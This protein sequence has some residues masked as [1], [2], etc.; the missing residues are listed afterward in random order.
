MNPIIRNEVEI[1]YPDSDGKPMADN[2]KQFECITKIKGNLDILFADNKDVFVAGD[3]LWY[4]VEGEPKIRIAPDVMV[5]IGRP[6]GHRGSYQQWKEGNIPPKVVFEILSPGNRYSEMLQK[7]E[8]YQ[9]Y[10][11]EEYYVYDPDKHDFSV[12]LRENNALT[13]QNYA[14]SFWKSPLLNITFEIIDT[15]FNI[16]YSDG[17]PFLSFVELNQVMQNA[18]KLVEEAQKEKA[19]AQ[20]ETA[21]AQKEKAEAQKEKEEERKAKENALAELATLKAQF[22]KKKKK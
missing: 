13:V 4:P 14:T 2:T 11:V 15:D 12:F 22:A 5:A 18:M 6:Q 16:Y 3:L 17:K 1:I 10:G 7:L 9:K 20:K 21:A 19:E 8:F